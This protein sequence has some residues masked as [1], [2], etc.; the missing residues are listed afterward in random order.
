[1]YDYANILF[2]GNACNLGCYGCIGENQQLFGLPNNLS[3]FPIRNIDL[4]LEKVNLYKIPDLAFTATN[5][6][7]QLYSH[8][9]ELINYVRQK[10][11]GKTKLSLHTNGLLALQKNAE[12]NSY[13]KVSV[14]FHSFNRETY[15]LMTRTGRQPDLAAIIKASR[16]PIKLSMF[17]SEHNQYE[18]EE[19]IQ[20]AADLG[21]RRLAIRKPKG[22][23]EEFPLENQPPF[24]NFTP[25]DRIFGWPV[26][27]I[28]GVETT[29]CGFDKSTANGLFLFSDGRL[30][31]YLIR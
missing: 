13:D 22:R 9:G 2:T 29:I 25:I 19:Y 12:F 10:L 5:T 6:D 11:E 27:R 18:I 16:L 3:L 26:Y 31:G 15:Q 17:V 7:P 23:E 20:K 28:S 4:L 24:C 8:E 14:S 1:M 30:E 21:I